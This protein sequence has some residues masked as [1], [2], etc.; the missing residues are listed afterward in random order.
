MSYY[1]NLKFHNTSFKK[2][3]FRHVQL[4]VT[5]SNML[6]STY[7]TVRCHTV[8]SQ[9]VKNST[10]HANLWHFRGACVI[11]NILYC[12]STG[13]D[14]WSQFVF[15]ARHLP[16]SF[17]ICVECYREFVPETLDF[18]S[19]H[20]GMCQQEITHSFLQSAVLE[21]CWNRQQATGS[22]ASQ[23]ITLSNANMCPLLSQGGA[24]SHNPRMRRKCHRIFETIPDVPQNLHVFFFILERGNNHTII[25]LQSPLHEPQQKLQ[26]R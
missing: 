12:L 21:Q 11:R 1:E 6:H 24:C 19:S 17:E 7:L 16:W 9:Y 4:I 2:L 25:K 8:C 15:S 26:K 3:S 10:I 13:R 23:S 22:C 5:G 14:S 20:A 18:I